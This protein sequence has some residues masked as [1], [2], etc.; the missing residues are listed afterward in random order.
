MVSDILIITGVMLLCLVWAHWLS[1]PAP[2]QEP[3]PAAEPTVVYRV[4]QHLLRLAA[5]IGYEG[6][7]LYTGSIGHRIHCELEI[8]NPQIAELREE[9]RKA[10]EELQVRNA[11]AA[12]YQ[13]CYELEKQRWDDA[14]QD[15]ERQA[16]DGKK[17][18]Y[19]RMYERFA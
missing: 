4:P 14:V 10:Q 2:T 1:T 7:H 19:T 12:A 9:L 11:E 16:A 8:R 15:V 13:A 18:R 3:E 17:F 6:D 5:N